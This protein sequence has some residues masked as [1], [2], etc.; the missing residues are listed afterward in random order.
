MHQ[1]YHHHSST[2][3]VLL[4][5]ITAHTTD[6]YLIAPCLY[7]FPNQPPRYVHTHLVNTSG[8]DHVLGASL[9]L[10]FK[11]DVT[12]RDCRWFWVGFC[13]VVSQN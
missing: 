5:E 10:K 11:N 1:W 4:L 7:C 12:I 8:G 6:H 2:V 9:T 13:C 3:A